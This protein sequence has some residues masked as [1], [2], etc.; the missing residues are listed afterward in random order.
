MLGD[1]GKEWKKLMFF[2]LVML[3]NLDR[4]V[5]NWENF[6]VVGE[7]VFLKNVCN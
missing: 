5:E 3:I 4:F 6:E 7:K 2:C 1:I